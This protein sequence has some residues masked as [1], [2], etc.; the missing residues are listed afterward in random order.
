MAWELG[1]L[2]RLQPA[3]SRPFAR[4]LALIAGWL[5]TPVAAWAVSFLG[6]WLGALIGARATAGLSGVAWLTS[7]SLLGAV[8]GAIAWI[9]VMRRAGRAGQAET[10]G[11]ED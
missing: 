10:I 2:G 8:I 5:L 7:G 4:R 6:G 3:L 9:V 11:A 1:V